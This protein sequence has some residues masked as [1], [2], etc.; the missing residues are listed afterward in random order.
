[1]TDSTLNTAADT[2]DASTEVESTE[3][4]DSSAEGSIEAQAEGSEPA[5]DIQ[6]AVQEAVANG[7][8]KKEVQ[9]MLKKYSLRVNGKTVEKE[10]DFSDEK[11]MQKELQ[12]AAAGREAM[13]V[14]AE[15]E[16]ALK[17]LVE[18]LKEDP[19]SL[20]EELGMDADELAALRLQKKLEEAK[21]S[22]EQVE[23]ERMQKEIEEY[24][25][26]ETDREAQLKA[27]EA[28]REQEDAIKELD[29]EI[30]QALNAYTTLPKGSPIVMDLIAKNLNWAMDNH[31]KFGFEKPEDVKVEHILPSVE[32]DLVKYMNKFF[33]G[34][35]QDLYNKFLGQKASENMRQQRLKSAKK[36]NNISNIEK[37]TATQKAKEAESSKEKSN[38]VPLSDFFRSMR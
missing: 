13:E 27:A 36:T 37:T 32:K 6:E 25:K 15:Y 22:P 30:D 23:R 38:P 31:E 29:D 16:K 5:S 8:T 1:M 10:F 9:S 33:E 20:A 2:T 24:R 12:M 26:R 21:K 18:R 3:S 14:K 4:D 35:P 28:R 11:A 17:T 34:I 19:L 7:A